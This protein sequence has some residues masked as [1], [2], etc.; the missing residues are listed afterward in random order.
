MS[1]LQNNVPKLKIVLFC[2]FI[3]NK[4]FCKPRVKFILIFKKATVQIRESAPPKN[5]L[6]FN[7]E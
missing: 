7:K 6:M 5:K 1:G 2:F 4:S 3:F